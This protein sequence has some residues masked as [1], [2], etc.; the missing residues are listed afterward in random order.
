ME[1]I[2]ELACECKDTAKFEFVCKY[3]Y[4][5]KTYMTSS[6][7]EQVGTYE[8][9]SA[10]LCS[11]DQIFQWLIYKTAFSLQYFLKQ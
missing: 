2:F 9:N 1:A 7:K 8:H 4:L 6:L 5:H 11:F 10:Q 3:I